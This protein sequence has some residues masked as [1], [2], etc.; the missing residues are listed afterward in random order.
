M[1]KNSPNQ[2]PTSEWEGLRGR[3]GARYLN[4]IFRR[5]SEILLAG[6]TPQFTLIFPRFDTDWVTYGLTI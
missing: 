6:L 2:N 4:S 3:I 1:I 5:I